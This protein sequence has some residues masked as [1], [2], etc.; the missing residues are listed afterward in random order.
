MNKEMQVR[1]NVKMEGIDEAQKLLLQ[2]SDLF[3][4]L[5]EVL[6]KLNEV[7]LKFD[8][9]AEK[10]EQEFRNVDTRKINGNKEAFIDLIN[11]SQQV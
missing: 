1:L 2:A 3:K 6:E 11:R 10:L 5:G 8:L 4:Q 7:N 9:E